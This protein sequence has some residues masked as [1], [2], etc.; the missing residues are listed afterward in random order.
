MSPSVSS[1]LSQPLLPSLTV[2]QMS[3]RSVTSAQAPPTSQR[4]PTRPGSPA[5]SR[6]HRPDLLPVNIHS[7]PL[8]SAETCTKILY[9]EEPHIGG[10][11]PNHSQTRLKHSFRQLVGEGL[12]WVTTR[13]SVCSQRTCVTLDHTLITAKPGETQPRGWGVR[14]HFIITWKGGR[15]T[16]MTVCSHD[17]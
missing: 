15:K 1:L 11:T 2:K 13:P 4:G 16:R 17:L 5:A 9:S 3:Q 8:Q 10:E 14:G 7:L 12:C 6:P